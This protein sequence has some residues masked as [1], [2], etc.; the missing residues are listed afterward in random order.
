M[1][2]YFC[3]PAHRLASEDDNDD[4]ALMETDEPAGGWPEADAPMLNQL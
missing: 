2:C 4:N 3:I 1:K